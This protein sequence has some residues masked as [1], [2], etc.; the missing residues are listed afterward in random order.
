MTASLVRSTPPAGPAVSGAIDFAPDM[1]VVRDIDLSDPAGDRPVSR[2][3]DETWILDPAGSGPTNR[4]SVHFASTPVQFRDSLKQLVWCAA[5]VDT[6]M[7]DYSTR[8][9][10]P[11]RLAIGSVVTFVHQS[12]RPF[13]KWLDEQHIGSISDVDADDL[14][15]YRAHVAQQPTSAFSKDMSMGGL[16]RMWRYAP[17]LPPEDRL[18]QPPW[19]G[20]DPDDFDDWDSRRPHRSENRTPPDRS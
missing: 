9:N 5:N 19:E 10:V 20:A 16:W 8:T 15:A 17:L 1:L 11:P 14:A 6:P 13:L 3:S 2:F 4:C 12:W 7:N 18:M